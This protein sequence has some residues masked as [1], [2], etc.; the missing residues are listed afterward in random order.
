[1]WRPLRSS[2]EE[3][4]IDSRSL[5]FAACPETRRLRHRR[6]WHLRCTCIDTTRMACLTL[7]NKRWWHRAS[8]RPRVRRCRKRLASTLVAELWLAVQRRATAAALHPYLSTGLTWQNY[9]CV[10][11]PTPHRGRRQRARDNMVGMRPRGLV[12][13]GVTD[14]YWSAALSTRSDSAH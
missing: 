8:L 5:G 12:R 4:Q 3:G 7:I 10:V 6:H 14:S 9:R 13:T 11:Q 2:G 1:M